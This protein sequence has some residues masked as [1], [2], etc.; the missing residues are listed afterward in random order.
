MP[1]YAHT[2]SGFAHDPQ[3]NASPAE[4]AARFHASVSGAWQ[5]VQVPDGTLHGAKDNGGGNYT[6]PTPPVPPAPAYRK[7]LRGDRLEILSAVFSDARQTAIDT[8]SAALADDASKQALKRFNS[9]TSAWSRDQMIAF[10]TAL[11]Q[12]DV[13]NS[14]TGAAGKIT[15]AE[16]TA[17]ANHQLWLQ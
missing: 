8:A 16:I 1:L 17:I 9:E 4:Y 15:I 11:R 10:F 7:L 12:L 13:P 5:I 6:N 2:E 14:G 3:Q